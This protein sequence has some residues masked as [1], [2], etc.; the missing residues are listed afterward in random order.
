MEWYG[1]IQ[2]NQVAEIRV[3]ETPDPLLLS[4][5][6]KGGTDWRIGEDGDSSYDPATQVRTSA[7][8]YDIQAEKIVRTYAI[9][10]RAS[11]DYGKVVEAEVTDVKTYPCPAFPEQLTWLTDNGYLIIEDGDSSYDPVTQTRT[12]DPTY[13]IQE[14]K[15]V[16]TYAVSDKPL[17]D[18]K[19]AK[20][21]DVRNGA[22]LAILAEYPL[23]RQTNVANAIYGSEIG[24]PIKTHIA[25][26]IIESNSC[27]D[28]VD[29]AETVA[30]VRNVTPD[31]PVE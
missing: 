18:A 19:I 9:K 4:K 30:A 7:P 25:N 15:I 21:A 29:A 6:T 8:T 13:D 2:N 16:R 3:F 5:M 11:T 27:E 22:R 28:T 1:K 12:T 14:T 17:A 26:I 20:L 24:N 31:W 10:D 23:W